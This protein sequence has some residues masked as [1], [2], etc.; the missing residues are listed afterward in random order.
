MHRRMTNKRKPTSKGNEALRRRRLGDLQR[1]LR[2]RHHGRTLLT[3]DDAGREYLRELLLVASMAFNPERMM[4]NTIGNWAPWMDKA[5]AAQLID[6]VNSTPIFLRKP[7][8]RILGNRLRLTDY[9]RE[10]LGIRT[11]RPL[12]VTDEELERRRKA[13]DS[14]RQWRKRRAKGKK[15]RDAWLANCKSRTKPWEKRKP[16]ISRATWY[17][18]EGRK[19]RQFRE[20]G[21]SAIKFNTRA[22]G[23]VSVESLRRGKSRRVVAGKRVVAERDGVV[24]GKKSARG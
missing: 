5:E 14:E 13:K 12:D 24:R 4:R 22:E 6:D 1:L 20:T 16:P 9:E 11:I 17:R 8:G 10:T 3:D 23:L 19:V 2:H 15:P 7:N 18:E 21:V